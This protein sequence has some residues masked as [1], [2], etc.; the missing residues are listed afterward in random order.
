MIGLRQL[1]TEALQDWLHACPLRISAHII[2]AGRAVNV[3]VAFQDICPFKYFAS[4]PEEYHVARE[5]KTADIWPELRPRAARCGREGGQIFALFPNLAGESA[6][7]FKASAF[8]G[9][10]IEY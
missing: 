6:V 10:V 3:P 2:A 5:G 9:N 4:I 8:T 1:W 7:C